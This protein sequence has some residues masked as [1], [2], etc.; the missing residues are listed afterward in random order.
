MAET[1]RAFVALSLP[2]QI[3]DHLA[4]VQRCLVAQGALARWVRPESIHLTLKFM[5]PLAPEKVAAVV[6]ALDP[7]AGQSAPLQLS[8]LGLGGFPRQKR[9][10]VLWMGVGDQS[11]GLERLQAAVA[12]RLAAL[13]WPAEKRVFKGHLTLARAK[14]RRGFDPTLTRALPHCEPGETVAFRADELVLFRSRLRPEG[15]VY[16]K[17]YAWDLGAPP[18]A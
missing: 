16:D 1:F 3:R 4:R 8:A 14:G 5:G 11:D 6:A 10:R 15:A 17:L 13:G 2:Q 18:G 9:A 7:I 12:A